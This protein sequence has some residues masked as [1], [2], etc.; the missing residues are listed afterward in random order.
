[1]ENK[2]LSEQIKKLNY[3]YFEV[4]QKLIEY[5]ESIKKIHKLKESKLKNEYILIEL[6]LKYNQMLTE[7]EKNNKKIEELNFI[8]NKKNTQLK[9]CKKTLD[10]YSQ[11]NQKLIL[12]ADNIYT[13]PKIL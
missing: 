5:E 12:D 1:M 2:V 8:I 10:Y 13:S 4:L 6:E 3:L 7:F 9:Q 11:L